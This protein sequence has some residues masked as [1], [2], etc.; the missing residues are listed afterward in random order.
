MRGVLSRIR[1][2]WKAVIGFVGGFAGPII[3]GATD[4]LQDLDWANVTPATVRTAALTGALTGLAV[5]AKANV[6]APQGRHEA[7]PA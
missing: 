3:A 6:P 7:D 2:V 5:W 1:A 4:N